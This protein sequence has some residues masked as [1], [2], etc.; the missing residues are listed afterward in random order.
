MRRKLRNLSCAILC[1][2]LL[3]LNMP[4]PM[5]YAE[6]TGQKATD[7][8]ATYMDATY[9]DAP[10]TDMTGIVYATTDTKITD[11]YIA[12]VT[13][14][15]T[16]LNAAP[17]EVPE[18]GYCIEINSQDDWNVLFSHAAGD[19]SGWTT[20]GATTAIY[21]EKKNPIVIILNDDI[22]LSSNATL[23]C[24]QIEDVKK[25]FVLYGNG[26]SIDTDGHTFS[27][28]ANTVAIENTHIKNGALYVQGHIKFD[29]TDSQFS[30]ATVELYTNAV[31]ERTYITGCEFMNCPEPCI[32]SKGAPCPVSISDCNMDNCGLLFKSTNASCRA[33]FSNITAK[34]CTGTVL[35]QTTADSKAT[36]YIIE[37]ISNC[38]LSTSQP[39]KTAIDHGGSA[40]GEITGCTITGFDTGINLSG[41]NVSSISDMDT[42]TISDTTI[43][44]CITGLY[45]KYLSGYENA[46]ISNL[47]ME[48]REGASDTV[49]YK[50][51]GKLTSK[52]FASVDYDFSQMPQI[53]ACHITG[54]DTGIC[55]S[56]CTAVISGCGISDC[57]SGIEITSDAVAIVDTTLQARDSVYSVGVTTN[58]ICYLIDCDITDFNVGS[59]LHA[60]SNTTVIG[61]RYQNKDQNLI[62]AYQTTVYDTS[63]VGGKTSVLMRGGTSYFYGCVVE[64]DSDTTQSGISVESGAGT[65][66]VYSLERPYYSPNGGVYADLTQYTDRN[67]ND[68]KSEIFNCK[69]GIDSVRVVNIADT[70]VHDCET[71]LKLSNNNNYSYGNN[72]IE[73]CNN[74]M[75]VYGLYKNIDPNIPNFTDTHTDTIRNCNNDGLNAYFITSSP[76]EWKNRLEIYNCDN[77]GIKIT[78]SLT[79]ATVNVHDCK[80]GLYMAESAGNVVL[81]SESKVYDNLEWNV[82]DD[83]TSAYANFI[84]SGSE[85]RLTGGGVGNVYSKNRVVISA[86]DL[87]SD[88]SVYYLGTANGMYTFS[89]NNL[90]DTAVFD[91]VES[92][93]TIGRRIATLSTDI[94]SQM[95]AKKEGFVISTEKD[96][97][98]TY[99]I[100]AAGCNVT[101]DVTTNG[102]DTFSGGKLI[103]FSYLNGNAIDLTYTASKT[104][105]EF[106]GWNTDQ[107]ATEGLTTLTAERENITLYAIYKKTAY[108]NY[109]TYDTASDYRTAVSFYNN[110][111]EIACGLAAYNAGGEN[112]FA[113]Y[114]IDGDAAVSSADDLLK[115]GDD[116]TVSLDGLDVYCVYEKQG[117]LDY[118]KKDGTILSTERIT[119]YQISSDNKK[120][121]Y[122]IK[123]GEP[124]DGFTF[125]GWKDNND[126]SFVAGNTLSTEDAF[127]VLT[128]VYEENQETTTEETTTEETTTEEPTTEDTT[129]ETTTTEEATTEEPT[130]EDTTTETTTTEEA[131]TE[132]PTTEDTT[133]ETTTTETPITENTTT[134]ATTTETPTTETSTTETLTTE[135]STIET[136]ITEA[137]TTKTPASP[138]T[139]D[140]AEPVGVIGLGILFLLSILGVSL[141]I[142]RK[143]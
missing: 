94:T 108:I 23:V 137:P 52:D 6:N 34:N 133:T 54:F 111:D 9:M 14:I 2:C 135:A 126:N 24:Q 107:N 73:N 130:T 7:T 101:Y 121:I 8:D 43:T 32:W 20:S 4:G 68:G 41:C 141:K 93:Y 46:I 131:T 123:A 95:F 30:A 109:H 112:T 138:K 104:G 51:D 25:D 143:N 72:L 26:H 57:K 117:R 80:T 53:K 13:A 48:A 63:F 119:V 118:L 97:N 39:G 66:H 40:V 125:T 114:V 140:N 82:Y 99:A 100:F 27:L 44:D 132:E 79:S 56:S 31:T 67:V 85:G 76:M 96:G 142:K 81:A 77:Y 128:P 103:R 78:G 124:V 110:Q 42:V 60:S 33:S 18:G 1:T 49:G 59:D 38:E 3:M 134:E 98:T 84:I 120:F 139:G 29:C 91:T 105:Y 83:S 17:L 70:H 106:V 37:S 11:I 69:T 58:Y 127:I 47:T 36:P 75:E 88:D 12:S 5:S 15:D 10:D 21:F 113:G 116:V 136:S 71:G 86:N 64:G 90:H 61:C 122:T 35:G 50:G 28:V 115:A 129:T 92:G 74:G 16:L 65:L 102:G 62:G 87:Y 89:V 19:G 22:T 45:I 55:L